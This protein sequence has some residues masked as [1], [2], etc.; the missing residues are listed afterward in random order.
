VNL[1][2]QLNVTASDL[3][4]MTIAEKNEFFQAKRRAMF[5]A[6]MGKVWHQQD[7]IFHYVFCLMFAATD[8]FKKNTYPYKYYPL[9]Q[10]GLWRWRQ[11]DLD[12]ILDINNQGF[13]AKSYSTLVGDVTSTGSGSV[14]RGDNSVFW[15]LSR[16]VS[17]M[18][19]RQW[20]I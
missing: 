13:S 17:R 8:N 12:S 4:G 16:N 1:L 10:N 7:A 3:E 2:T 19:L 5:V 6:D 11:D 14:F 15:T 18:K 20:Y 9:A